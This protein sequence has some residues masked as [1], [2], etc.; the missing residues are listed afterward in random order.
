MYGVHTC[1]KRRSRTYLQ[2]EFPEFNIE[3]GFTEDDEL[4]DPNVR[5]LSSHVIE[6]AHSVLDFIFENNEGFCE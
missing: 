3:E 5:E 2:S 6:R 4:Y 1:D